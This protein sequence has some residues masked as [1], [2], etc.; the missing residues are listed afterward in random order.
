[1]SFCV[2]MPHFTNIGSITAEIWRLIDFQVGGRCGAILLP[3]RTGWRHFLQKVNVCQH[4]KYRQDNSIH[5]RDF[6]FAKTNVRHIEFLPVSTLTHN[7]NPH[8]ILHK[9]A[10][11]HLY[12]TTQCRN[13]TSYR[14]SRWRWRLNTTSDY[15]LVDAT[16]LG[17]SKSVSKLNFVDIHQFMAEI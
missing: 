5:G 3:Y 10:K 2:S 8:D 14:F 1:M 12:R 6:H 9:V 15:L 11:L 13:I 16:V 4:T 7:R 17:R